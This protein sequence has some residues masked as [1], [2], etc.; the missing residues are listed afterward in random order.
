MQ[1]LRERFFELLR[2][3]TYENPGHHDPNGG[4]PEHY[5]HYNLNKSVLPADHYELWLRS[6]DGNR[7][8]KVGSGRKAVY[9]RFQ[10][11]GNGHWH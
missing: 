10:N 2:L 4:G 9:H 1:D 11:D 6:G 3:G 8:T 7:Y 5:E